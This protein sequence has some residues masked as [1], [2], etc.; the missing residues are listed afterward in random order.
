MTDSLLIISF[1]KNKIL[2]A[3]IFCLHSKVCFAGV[4]SQPLWVFVVS[5]VKRHVCEPV[6]CDGNLLRHA[7]TIPVD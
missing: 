6:N 7:R 4:S 3:L 5:F 2:G 1:F